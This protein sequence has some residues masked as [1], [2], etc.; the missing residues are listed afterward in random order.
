MKKQWGK[1]DIHAVAKAAG[2]SISTVSR[3]FNHPELLSP[4]TRR[5]IDRAVKKT[6]YIRNRAA[7]TMHG[8]RSATIGLVVPTIDHAIFGEVVQAFSDS[9]DAAGF[10]ILMASHGFDLERE[11]QVL[12]KFLEHR[13]DGIAL[14]GLDHAEATFQL[15]E[16]QDIPAIS[17][18]NYDAQSRMACVGADN[19]QAGR[20]AAE[21]LIENGHRRIATVFP[22]TL[23]ND[24]ARG[25]WDGALDSLRQAGVD[26]PQ[27]WQSR[28]PYS[29]A[30]AKRACAK[31]LALSER[32]SALLCGNDVIAQGAIF[33]AQ[34]AG[35]AVPDDLSI[36]GIGDFKGSGEM[37]PALTTIRIPARQIGRI[38]GERI[39]EM[40]TEETREMSRYRCE[41]RLIE[42]QSAQLKVARSAE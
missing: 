28:A 38:A 12:R 7:Q 17:M 22:E 18:W 4:A 35:V 8:R 6:G 2:V 39:V 36:F 5:K 21:W 24:R 13:V 3:S 10:T 15:I 31:I 20:L 19:V 29:I 34:A 33:A 41:L 23:Q 1:A 9:V 30:E 16:E 37:E 27:I 11:Y 14:I 42:R 25:R 32:P 40:I 26:V